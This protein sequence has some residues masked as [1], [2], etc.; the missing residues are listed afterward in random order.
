MKSG[1]P[2]KGSISENNFGYRSKLEVYAN[3]SSDITK[4]YEIARISK[5]KTLKAVCR[6]K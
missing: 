6:F 4:L 1:Q 5:G 2:K 3:I